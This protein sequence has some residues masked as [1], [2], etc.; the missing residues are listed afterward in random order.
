MDLVFSPAALDDLEEIHRY[1][2]RENPRAAA[3]VLARLDD[4]FQKLMMGEIQGPRVRLLSGEQ[5]RRWPVP[6][7]R[8]YY[9]RTASQTHILRVYHGALR[10]IE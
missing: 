5:A 7:Y 3:A 8:I 4:V 10:P 2:A 1:I 9:E 6:P